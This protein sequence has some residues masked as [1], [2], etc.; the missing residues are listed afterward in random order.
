VAQEDAQLRWTRA[1]VL[2][3]LVG[4]LDEGRLALYPFL[5]SDRRGELTSFSAQGWDQA[6]AEGWQVSLVLHYRVL[7]ARRWLA[8]LWSGESGRAEA[9][10]L[11]IDLLK[12]LGLFV[13][14]WW[15]QRR[16][17]PLIARLREQYETPTLGSGRPS[18]AGGD[19]LLLIADRVRRPVGWLLACWLTLVILGAGVSELLEVELLWILISWNLGGMLVVDLI[20]AVAAGHDVGDAERPTAGLRLRSLKLVGRVVVLVGLTLA[21]TSRLVGQ[22]TIYDWVL[23]TC[24]FLALPVALWIVV[25]WRE[26]I[27]ER[28]APRAPASSVAVWVVARQDRWTSFAA[29]SVGGAYLLGLGAARVVKRYLGGFVVTRR[30]LAYLFRRELAKQSRRQEA[31]G[32]LASIPPDRCTAFDSAARPGGCAR[33]SR[34]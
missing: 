5:S 10:F 31:E 34:I 19:H 16:I 24:W 3:E 7:A 29:A 12:A 13:V 20:D 18:R 32:D 14:L 25:W 1:S 15:L 8:G 11:G 17:G 33:W 9:L 4:S 28:L 2:R 27:F 22:G 6:T 23:S 26:V 21:L 30:L